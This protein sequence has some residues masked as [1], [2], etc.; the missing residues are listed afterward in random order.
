MEQQL[1]FKLN[2]SMQI[3]LKQSIMFVA[4]NNTISKIT[5]LL[6]FVTDMYM[7]IYMYLVTMYMYSLY[8]CI[9]SN[10]RTSFKLYI[11]EDSIIRIILELTCR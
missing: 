4:Y 6:L 2:S 5:F 9:H 1:L 10:I 8:T 11:N 3:V 7:Y